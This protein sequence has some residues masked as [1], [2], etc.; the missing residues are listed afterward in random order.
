MMYLKAYAERNSVAYFDN[1]KWNEPNEHPEY[2]MICKGAWMNLI[3]S[4]KIDGM[5][6]AKL[7][8]LKI[9]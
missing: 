6:F 9:P 8:Q 5:Y 3:D 2:S 7:L 4:Q 1:R